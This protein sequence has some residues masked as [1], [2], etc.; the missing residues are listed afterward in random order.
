MQKNPD[1]FYNWN[2]GGVSKSLQIEIYS[3]PCTKGNLEKIQWKNMM[4]IKTGGFQ[5]VCS[6]VLRSSGVTQGA[7]RAKSEGHCCF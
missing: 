5:T 6:R 1:Y 3:T 2:G 7:E 4:K